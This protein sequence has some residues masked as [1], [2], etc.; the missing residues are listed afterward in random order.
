MKT[1]GKGNFKAEWSADIPEDGTYEIFAM[2]PKATMYPPK[3]LY[4]TVSGE[5]KEAEEI[6]LDYK[7]GE[8]TSLGY[9]DL[10]RGKS[11]VV[12]D[13][14]API[15][16]EENLVIGKNKISADAVKWVKVN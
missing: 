12:L 5:G 13:D 2:H 11:F 9:F 1:S 8:W 10:K 7:N 16:K 3:A 4:Y 15:E 6:L 14:R